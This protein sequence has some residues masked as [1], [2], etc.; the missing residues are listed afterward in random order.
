M[1]ETKLQTTVYTRKLTNEMIDQRLSISTQ[2]ANYA[3]IVDLESK[4]SFNVS[5][6]VCFVRIF[7]KRNIK[8]KY[9][10]TVVLMCLTE[11]Q[12]IPIT[13]R[14]TKCVCSQKRVTALSLR[15]TQCSSNK[16][17]KDFCLVRFKV[18][19]CSLGVC[20]DLWPFLLSDYKRSRLPTQP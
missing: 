19:G 1:C 15:V 3:S 9:C 10:W 18:S 4:W 17:L 7:Y 5:Y 6:V 12:V 2:V 20:T 8:P 14:C 16:S 13:S 11:R